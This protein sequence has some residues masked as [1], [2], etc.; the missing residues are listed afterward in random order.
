VS[1]ET[2]KPVRGSEPT[3]FFS[4]DGSSLNGKTGCNDFQ[5]AYQAGQ[6]NTLSIGNQ[7]S[8]QAACA[9]D[10]LTRQEKALLSLLGG[11]ASY[12]ISGSQLQVRT[13]QG[14][15][16]NFSS[17]P[18]EPVGP[19]AVI[20]GP[21][22]GLVGETLV[23][24]GYKSKAGTSPIVS[25]VWRMGDG[26]KFH[27]PVYEYSYDTP[28]SY[29]V[30]LEVLDEAT[31]SHRAKQLIQIN[32]AVQVKP[33]K[34]AIEGPNMAFVG[35]A[36]TLSAA[37]SKKGSA[38]ITG[39]QWRSGDNNDT[40][41]MPENSFTT[42]YA[43]PGTYYPSVLVVDA[44]NQTDSASMEIVI[45]ARLEGTAWG[46]QGAIPGT[47]I[48]LEFANGMLSGFSGCNTYNASYI[49]TLAAGPSNTISVGPIA[50]TGQQCSEE[51]MQQEQAYLTNL[52][53]ASSYL[54]N[55]TTMTMTTASGPLVFGA[56]IATPAAAAQ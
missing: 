24:D 49:T 13:A 28:G 29:E 52:P 21:T 53:T 22:S 31:L 17:I 38:D 14:G 12:G 55:G 3:V 37:N 43:H 35:D 2:S 30:S 7:S 4:P 19:T 34:A 44:A 54:I 1:Y 40:A 25:Y 42:I 47:H 10:E 16:L 32:A 23:F 26:T 27:G 15:T 5:A 39:Y 6:G 48:S 8:T 36:V 45:N 56:A 51:I 11:A 18:P 46:L 9:S 41:V 20:V 50:N 33:P